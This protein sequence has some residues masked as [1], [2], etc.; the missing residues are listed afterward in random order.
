MGPDE[1]ASDLDAWRRG[2]AA[3]GQRLFQRYFESL[4]V[5]LSNK[6]SGDVSDLV[7]RTMLACVEARER[8]DKPGSFKA[9]LLGIARYVLIDHYRKTR[10]LRE[11]EVTEM[12][13]AALAGSPSSVLARKRQTR[14]LLAA[15]RSIPLDLQIAVELHYWESMTAAELGVVLGVPTGTAKSRLRRARERL[16]EALTSLSELD[17]QSTNDDQLEQWVRSM[18]EEIVAAGIPRPV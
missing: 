11:S 2:D 4:Y 12:S 17:P 9:Y 15:L 18:R 1:D 6:V 16:A 8:I 10:R 13:V 14:L 5:F 7:Q 3:A